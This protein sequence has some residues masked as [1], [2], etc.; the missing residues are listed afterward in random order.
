M[1]SCENLTSD[2][3]KDK[4]VNKTCPKCGKGFY[5]SH[6]ARCWCVEYSLTPEARELLESSYSDCLCEECL[7]GFAS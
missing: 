4:E 2:K 6:S 1:N 5:C 3:Q 7:K